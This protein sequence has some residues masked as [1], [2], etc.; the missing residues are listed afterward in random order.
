MIIRRNGKRNLRTAALFMTTFFLVSCAL[1][2]PLSTKVEPQKPVAVHPSEI[3]LDI[4]DITIIEDPGDT[5]I[6]EIYKD[7]V[8]DNCERRFIDLIGY[9]RNGELLP[10][11][12]LFDNLLESLEYLYGD[13]KVSDTVMLQDF[14]NEFSNQS[15]KNSDVNIF[16]LYNSLYLDENLFASKEHDSNELVIEKTEPQVVRLNNPGF[17]YVEEKTKELFSASGK[18]APD[19]FVKSVYENYV[20]YLGDR[21][22]IKETYL[23]SQKYIGFIKTKLKDNGLSEIYAYI[24]AVT[25]S[26]YEGSKNG[27]IW[28]V[29]NIKDYRNFRNDTG[30]STALVI[31]KIK[32][33]SAKNNQFNIIATFLE[34]G[35]YN[36]SIKDLRTDIYT[37]NFAGFIAVLIIL[38][39]PEDH[40]FDG[41]DIAGDEEQRYFASY[42]DYVKNPAKFAEQQKQTTSA[43]PSTSSASAYSKS[44]IRIMYKVKKGD[45]LDKIAD[46][47]KVSV[48]DIKKWNPKDT[49]KKYL[50]P[51]M[52]FYIQGDNFQY[53]KAKS[54]DSIGRI[55]SMFGMSESDFKKINDLSSNTIYKGRKY[56]VRKK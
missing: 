48:N 45:N 55:T 16:D 24:P 1:M 15:I 51:G 14:W 25:T 9:Y 21:I 44:F 38:S 22:G 6:I 2:S 36:L 53:Y 33:L 54:G 8:L 27:S 26:F 37:D 10:A 32:E 47:F 23:R 28:R 17:I 7:E 40:G 4:R 12:I 41:A 35:K 42:E 30:A 56:I 43:K 34:E 5:R 46:L 20:N 29:E 19:D 13:R 49:A 18:A 39:N 52:T 3:S 11:K 50:Y 31:R